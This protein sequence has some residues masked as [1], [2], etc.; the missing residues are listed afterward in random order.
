MPAKK[1]AV[2]L[3]AGAL[4]LGF[5]G[6]LFSDRWDLHFVDEK[7]EVLRL[8]ARAKRVKVNLVT[9][10]AI[11]TKQI[12][13]ASS[14]E[15][16]RTE[17]LG[18]LFMR[19]PVVLTATSGL[20][21]EEVAEQYRPHFLKRAQRDLPLHVLCCENQIGPANQLRESLQLPSEAPIWFSDTV[22]G[23]TCN[24]GMLSE[25]RKGYR[26]IGRDDLAR[27]IEPLVFREELTVIAED[28]PYLVA[29][30]EETK[31]LEPT[32]GLLTVA[33]DEFRAFEDQE[34]YLHR[35]GR[36]LL[37]A[38][39]FL[40][41]HKFFCDLWND[42]WIRSAVRAALTEEL[43]P[44]LEKAYSALF[45]PGSQ[46]IQ[47]ARI[48]ERMTSPTL[49]DSVEWVAGDLARYLGARE[50]FVEGIRFLLA[51]GIQPCYFALCVPA[52]YRLLLDAGETQLSFS[53]F[54]A[55][56]CAIFSHQ[57]P[58]ILKTCESSEEL[59][60]SVLT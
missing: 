48:L 23:S 10:S 8:L 9:P 22:A 19:V 32:P 49:N 59:L 24:L 1:E 17:E 3:G 7:S 31:H 44:G 6:P 29:Q 35:A 20:S 14:I 50:I 16:S 13:I 43:A 36:G 4:S 45:P 46:A 38:L 58:D 52:G 60:R 12:P 53:D 55:Y 39:G 28:Y 27:K 26:S 57:D 25:L 21:P 41:G 2:V 5:L 56:H 33:P 34:K 51:N 54:L 42:S 47:A 37:G 11:Q 40:R 15:V 18:D 30:K